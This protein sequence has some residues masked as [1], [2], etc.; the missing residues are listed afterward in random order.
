MRHWV[1]TPLVGGPVQV[2][3]ASELEP[4]GDGLLPHRLPA[5]ARA[6]LPDDFAR[7]CEEQ[8]SGVRLV[9]RTAA[10][11]LELDVRAVRTAMTGR[12]LSPAGLYDVVVDGECV[13]QGSA[14]GYGVLELDPLSR[15]TTVRSGPACTVAF[16]TLEAGEKDVEIWLPFAE[17]T[18][19]VALRS[20]L[21]IT[22]TKGSG[23]RRRWVHHGS[24]ISHGAGAEAPTGTWPVVAARRAGWDLVNLGFS[25]NAVLDPFTARAI[26]DQPADLITLKIGINVVNLDCF[27]LRA[28]VPAVH[29]FLDTIREGHPSTPILVISPILCPLV[30]DCPGPTSID[31]A[32]SPDAPLFR[33]SGRREELVEGK[34]SLTVIRQILAEVVAERVV[35]DPHLG[36]LD[37]RE[38]FGL[39]DL[40]MMPLP[41]LLHPDPA[42]H[43]HIGTRFAALLPG[44][45]PAL[46]S[47]R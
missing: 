34:L 31:P 10:R 41:D 20:D 19:L 35:D 45:A 2:L 11:H 24:S 16:P 32:S 5:A 37:G 40:E 12:P 26:R 6:Q 47:A 28:F 13:A 44:L 43:R 38:L 1:G 27:R 46:V 23:T 18:R 8:P 30:E 3:G 29:G 17:V 33:T 4:T 15:T 25:G 39:S 42:G 14:P 7:M 36:Y 22:P 21:P 9:F